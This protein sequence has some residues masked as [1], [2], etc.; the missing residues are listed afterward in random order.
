[1]FRFLAFTIVLA[2][3]CPAFAQQQT[4][5][6][7]AAYQQLLAEA[8]SRVAAA[9]AQATKLAKRVQELENAAKTPPAPPAEK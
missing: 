1:M 6:E 2:L 9:S 5:P 3:A 8:N 4:D 7:I